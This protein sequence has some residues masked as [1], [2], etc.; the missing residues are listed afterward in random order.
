[1]TLASDV[2]IAGAGIIG[3]AAARALSDA[4]L[5]VT[6]VEPGQPG[7][8]ASSAAAGLIS[9]QY[10]GHGPDPLFE[11]CH[12]ARAL[13]PDFVGTLHDETGIDPEMRREGMLLLAL[14]ESDEIALAELQRWQERRGLRVER[15]DSPE[16]RKLERFANPSVRWALYLPD[17]IQI[18]N[19]KLCQALFR[20]LERRRIDWRLGESVAEVEME[21]GKLRSVRT[22]SGDRIPGRRLVIAAGAWS[23]RLAGLVRPLPVR[24]LRGHIVQLQLAQGAIQRVLASRRSYAVPRRDG[25][26]LL[27]STVEDVG[28]DPGP[29]SGG[30]REV[31][32]NA[33]EIAP[34]L[35]NARMTKAW[36]GFRP[37]TPD[38]RPIIGEDPEVPGLIYATGHFRNGIL[39]API[40]ARLVAALASGAAVDQDLSDFSPARFSSEASDRAP[41]LKAEKSAGVPAHHVVTPDVDDT[42]TQ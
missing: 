36:T 16:V 5:S 21:A 11:L 2:I 24:P 19:A 38:G 15:I 29:T 1:M 10:E 34:E 41:I 17:E 13:Y 8:E 39:L 26:L 40:T 20:S 6:I 12:Q 25:R 22:A 42:G 28:F 4:G 33:F 18:D 30:V 32:S 35:A 23:G 3:C 7:R 14:T 37:G 9:P 27:G 31:L